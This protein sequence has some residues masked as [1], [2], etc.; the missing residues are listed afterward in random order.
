MDR[1]GSPS[2]GDWADVPRSRRGWQNVTDRWR[3][4]D[5]RRRS[6]ALSTGCGRLTVDEAP[7]SSAACCVTGA[8]VG[9]AIDGGMVAS[10]AP[11]ASAAPRRRRYSRRRR[12]DATAPR[13]APATRR[14]SISR[15]TASLICGAVGVCASRSRH[16]RSTSPWRRAIGAGVQ[17]ARRCADAEVRS[18]SRGSC[19]RRAERHGGGRRPACCSMQHYRHCQRWTLVLDGGFLLERRAAGGAL[20]L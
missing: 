10:D 9:A 12:A 4:G 17:R 16:G 20:T 3:L 2:S 5:A 7:S 11:G 13:L 15:C 18:A 19:F 1:K 6:R 8:S 14:R